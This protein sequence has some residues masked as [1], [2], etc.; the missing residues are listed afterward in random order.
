MS[1]TTYDSIA[2]PGYFANIAT[3]AR[4]LFDAIFA[5]Q[6][7]VSQRNTEETIWWLNSLANDCERHS[8]SLSAELR[9]FASRG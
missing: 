9:Y 6:P 4:Q 5:V 7:A 3:A 1:A 8:P 2:T